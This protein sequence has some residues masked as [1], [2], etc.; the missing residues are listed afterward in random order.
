MPLI[1]V[2]PIGPGANDTANLNLIE[3]YTLKI[4][5]GDRR[6]GTAQ[7]ITNADTGE[8]TF[9]KPVDNIGRKSIANYEDYARNHI[10]P[11]TIP[12]CDDGRVFV[13]QRR[14]SFFVNLGE[15]FDLVNIPNP[16]GEQFADDM[17]NVVNSK[18]ITSLVLEVPISC[19]TQGDAGPVIGGWTTAS[20]RQ[21]RI[22]NPQP[23]TDPSEQGATVEG[24]AFTQ[25]SRLSSPL[26][27]EVI[28]GVKDKDRFN[29]S[30]PKNDAQFL[31]YVTHPTLPEILE[32]LFG[33]A[34]VKAPD[35]FPRDDLVAAFL[36]GLPASAL[37]DVANQPANVTPSEMMR[38]NTAVT[39][40]PRDSQ[41][42]LGVLGGDPAGFPNG[43]RPGD[44]VVDIEL[45]VAM[46]RLIPILLGTDQIPF[47]GSFDLDFTDGAF[48]DATDFDNRFPYLVSP[49]PGSPVEESKDM[50]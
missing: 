5:R 50:D 40:T 9:I 18:N 8:T 25:V 47:A 42:R 35:I 29:A 31:Q 16:I 13:G 34:G 4:V 48:R 44:D 17:A 45:R 33:A 49:L 3:Q 23:S 11:I 20:L 6:T 39:V 12:G 15:V 27:N 22:L 1:N 14:E 41:S 19:L 38:L 43:R 7:D 36:T 28:I 46:G 10:Y 2:G 32:I 21:A 26:V 24:G 30:E 37:P